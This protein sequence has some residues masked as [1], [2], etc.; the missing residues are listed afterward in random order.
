MAKLQENQSI[1]PDYRYF[2]NEFSKATRI[3]IFVSIIFHFFGTISPWQ[4]V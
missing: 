1:Q 2:S 4:Y 3:C